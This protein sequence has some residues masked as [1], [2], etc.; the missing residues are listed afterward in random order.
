MRVQSKPPNTFNQSINAP[1]EGRWWFRDFMGLSLPSE[2]LWR[3]LVHWTCLHPTRI[4]H[5][6]TEHFQLHIKPQYTSPQ[7][8]WSAVM[9]TFT[10]PCWVF[11][12]CYHKR[13]TQVWHLITGK[14]PLSF[15][16][17]LDHFW[18]PSIPQSSRCERA[19]GNPADHRVL[20]FNGTCSLMKDHISFHSFRK[21]SNS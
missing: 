21:D 19:W 12:P 6:H 3:R 10:T 16:Q 15:L 9:I 18:K 14:V 1:V 2:L 13:T 20:G 17:P 8:N 7:T 5:A 11:T 4:C